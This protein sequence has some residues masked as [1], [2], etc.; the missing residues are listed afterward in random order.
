MSGGVFLSCE[1]CLAVFVF[2][3]LVASRLFAVRAALVGV[4]DVCARVARVS[5]SNV[6]CGVSAQLSSG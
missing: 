2:A 5:I 4:G 3:R 1:G 6:T